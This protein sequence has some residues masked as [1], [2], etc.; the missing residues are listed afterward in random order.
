[1]YAIRS[2]Y[3]IQSALDAP[4]TVGQQVI[5][6]LIGEALIRQEAARRDITVTSDEVENFKQEQFNYYPNG[7]PS[8]TVTPTP[9]VVTYPTLSPEQL[10]P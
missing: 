5:D 1:M 3:E 8:P 7:T 4:T 10:D 2:Y 6:L 9:V